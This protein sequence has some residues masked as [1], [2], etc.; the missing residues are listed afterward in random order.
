[1]GTGGREHALARA[2]VRTSDSIDLVLQAGTPGMEACGRAVAFTADDPV[3]VARVAREEGV[4][5]VV[6]GAPAPQG[7]PRGGPPPLPT[8]TRGEGGGRGDGHRGRG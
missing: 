1:M 4:D 7:A 6:V 8:G 5:L 2:L 3:A